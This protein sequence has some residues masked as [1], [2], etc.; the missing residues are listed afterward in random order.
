MTTGQHIIIILYAIGL[1]FYPRCF[2]REFEAEMLDVF[3]EAAMDAVAQTP[4]SLMKLL[5]REVRDFP[6]AVFS[7]HLENL[8]TRARGAMMQDEG[9]TGLPG[10]LPIQLS[11]IGY[12]LAFVTGKRLKIVERWFDVVVAIL[13]VIVTAPLLGLIAILIKL[14]SPGPIIFQQKRAGK[15]GE[16]FTLYKFRSMIYQPE[17]Q[18]MVITRVGHWLRWLRW[19]ETPQL[20]NILKGDMCLFGYRPGNPKV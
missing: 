9:Q 10:V 11:P 8:H 1:H 17:S 20:I 19:D 5:L 2:R 3:T 14:D 16:V 18:R 12:L 13:L 7:A 6:Y 15:N 4:L